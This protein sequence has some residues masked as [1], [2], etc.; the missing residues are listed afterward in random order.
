[1][2]TTRVELAPDKFKECSDSSSGI[3]E[4]TGGSTALQQMGVLDL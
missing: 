2:P 4:C 3:K 1:M